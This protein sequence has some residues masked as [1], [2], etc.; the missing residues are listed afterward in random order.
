MTYGEAL[1]AARRSLSAAGVESAALDARLLLA[2]ASGL[3]MAALVA[4]GRDDLPAVVRVAF[5]DHMQR[6][7]TGEPL[8]PDEWLKR[9]LPGPERPRERGSSLPDPTAVERR[10]SAYI[11]KMPPAISGSGGHM[12]TWQVALVL[13]K[14]FGLPNRTLR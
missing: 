14:G 9:S 10:A 2:A 8:N 13:A 12:A 4:R 6:R 5:D 7:L 11:A 1:T 3:D